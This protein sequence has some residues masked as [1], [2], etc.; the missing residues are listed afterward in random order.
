MRRVDS[1]ITAVRTISRNN[2]NADGT[3]AISDNEILQY[4]NDA[5]DRIQNL[6]SSTK[7]I[8]KIFVTQQIISV[9]AN[10]E[11]YSVP[12]RVLL[13]KQIE[14]VEFSATSSV[15]DYVRLEK[16]NFF[17][18]DTNASNYPWGYIKRGNQLLLQ[19]TP[20]ISTGSI[21]VTYERDLDDLD[22]PR[23]IITVVTNGTSTQFDTL[24]LSTL[25]DSYE[26]T[27]PGWSNIQYCSVVSSIGVRKTYNILVS[28]YNTGTNVITPSP[29]PL[30]FT[31][32]DIVPAVGDVA[33]FGQYTTTFS[34]LPDNCERYLIH[35]A[36]AECFHR[37]SS[38][39]Y[40]DELERVDAI[41]KDILKALSSQTSEVQ[42]IPQMDR[43]EWQLVAQKKYKQFFAKDY[44]GIDGETT[45][46]EVDA[47]G[48]N[49]A[50]NYEY[51][52]GNSLRGRVG[53]QVAAG[54]Y[55]F[56]AIFPYSYTRTQDQYDI[57]Y[58]VSTGSYPNET[59]SIGTTK[60]TAD[61]ASITK[62]IAINE[63][64][65]VRDT[66]NVTITYVS[67]TY[68]FTWYT[69]VSGS[70]IN[71]IIKA[72][73][74]SIL[75]QVLGDIISGSTSTIYSLLVAIDALSQLSVS[76]TTRG[77]GP[78][79]AFV[80]GNQTSISGAG[81][82]YGTS[83]TVTVTAGHTFLPGDII[84]F[85]NTRLVGG[86]VISITATTITYVGNSVTLSNGQILGYMGQS[87]EGYEITTVATAL[88]GNL[89]LS[90]PYWRLIPEGDSS[91]SGSYGSIYA[92]PIT[93]WTQKSQ[94]SFYAPAVA[95]SAQ[96]CLFVAASSLISD[97]TS[98][99]ANN[100]IKIDSISAM[101]AGLPPP[102]STSVASGGGGALT[103][104]YKY[105][106]FYR[107]YD[108]QGNIVEGPVTSTSSITVSAEKVTVACTTIAYTSA[109]GFLGRSAFK[110]TTESPTAG[111]FFKVDDNTGGPL[112][113]FLQPGD[114]IVL[115]D[116]IAQKVGSTL[117]TLHRTVCTAYDGNTSPSSIKVADSSGYQINNNTEIST[118]L[119]LVT[120]R[121]A[122][123]GN[124]F[125][126]V[127][128][129][130]VTGYASISWT[131]NVAD[132]VLTAGVQFTDPVL[133]KEH[134]PPPSCSLVCQHQS[135]LVVARG[136]SS[137]NTVSFSTA[138]GIEYFPTASNSFDIPSTQSGFV[139]AIASDTND[140]LAV[141]KERAYYDVAGDLD[142][143]IFSINVKNEGDFGIV[144]QA[145]L[146]RVQDVL[147]GLSRNGYVTIS[148]G[149]LQ[150]IT[151]RELNTRVIAQ[152]YNFAWAVACNDALSRRYICS[153]P[154]TAAEPVTHV[155]DYS[156]G[157][158]KTFE[159]SYPTKI[160]VAGGMT[161]VGE[162]FFHL[163]SNSPYC[164]FR[165]L[166]RFSGDSPSGNGNGDSF[167]D[168]VNAISYILE[169][170]AISNG[171]PDVLNT[172]IRARAWSL[173]NDYVQ[174]GW[175]P[176]SLLI[177]GGCS[178]LA[179]Y[180]G[181]ANNN[182]T[183]STVT[184]STTNDI[185]KDITLVSTKTHFYVIRFTTNTIRT[186]PFFS[187]YEILYAESY[188]PEDLIK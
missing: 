74:V 98:R 70:A 130:P 125:Y 23:G 71:F 173:P 159:L 156:R 72:N 6:I 103:G 163:S 85:N 87:V 132:T 106:W 123:G 138:T 127:G 145:S 102:T 18:R 7:N 12:D 49:R 184:F 89:T 43:Y 187:G 11:A 117:G 165:R 79:I 34:Q 68:P 36:A 150:W 151:F 91:A 4:L 136:F 120:L 57:L 104:T 5:Q 172:P 77:V 110:N 160:D 67:G 75:N 149:S 170:N 139:T 84:T 78:P 96:G 92:S 62:L 28:S 9:V 45:A 183:S 178:P 41:E 47:G 101:R 2:A 66:L 148:D 24:T 21:R 144:S 88:S 65:W 112:N 131:D 3:V 111:Q 15:A 137:P 14:S 25:A 48:V 20:S 147:L 53:C 99:Y 63:Q 179:A 153:I 51:A 32:N 167:I 94:N 166:R 22:I 44:T 124:L 169:S 115:M 135:G 81:T 108:A 176:F 52:V 42:F 141:T 95:T 97:G 105:R 59:G 19:P 186:A 54:A 56:M 35:Y 142:G 80:N 1:L 175:V 185:F 162:T 121:T 83:Q 29:S 109:T 181:S 133:G 140:R 157:D 37:D 27:T 33:V 161:I 69:T 107:K 113:A 116:S 174:E 17:N 129:I 55:S 82:G 64:V 188:Q 100:L 8:A 180:V 58:Q 30:I 46:L 38:N 154:I 60:T 61:G 146:V 152:N 93:L 177:E 16:L 168:N 86:L 26:S 122:A 171:E 134:N 164:I 73:G 31:T 118:G 182:G 10:Q 50:V 126:E 13:N 119:T 114:P 39:D 40:S 76:P 155:I 128:E 90:F 158:L 143:G